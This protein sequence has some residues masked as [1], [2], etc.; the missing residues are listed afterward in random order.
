MTSDRNPDLDLPGNP[1]LLPW[2]LEPDDNPSDRSRTVD[3]EGHFIFGDNCGPTVREAKF[4]ISCVNNND[5][6]SKTLLNL[7]H[8]LS[9]MSKLAKA[10]EELSDRLERMNFNFVGEYGPEFN[11][12]KEMVSA[13]R[14]LIKE[15]KDD[16]P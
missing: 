2:R 9:A 4:I 8:R 13:A 15:V 12:N 3:C 10:V 6:A 7:N 1:M 16:A 11:M 5:V 14:A